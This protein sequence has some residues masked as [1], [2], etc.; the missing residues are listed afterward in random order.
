[1]LLALGGGKCFCSIDHVVLES[2][3]NVGRKAKQMMQT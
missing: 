3:L 2:A 1:M